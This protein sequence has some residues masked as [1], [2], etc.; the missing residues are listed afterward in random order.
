MT[1]R[2]VQRPAAKEFP[3]LISIF[4]AMALVMCVEEG[5]R[6]FFAIMRASAI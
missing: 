3:R 1:R 2:K 5:P 4:K 6:Y